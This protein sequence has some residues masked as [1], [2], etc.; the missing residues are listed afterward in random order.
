MF[1]F[2]YVIDPHAGSSEI[3][4]SSPVSKGEMVLAVSHLKN[5]AG[6][7]K[8][9]EMHHLVHR[10][11]WPRY[12]SKWFCEVREH[13]KERCVLQGS[14]KSCGPCVVETIKVA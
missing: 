2:T 4:S 3:L 12:S 11:V 1:S 10:G 8:F 13:K 5:R 7:K 6:R 14:N 9:R